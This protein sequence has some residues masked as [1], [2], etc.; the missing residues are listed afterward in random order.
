LKRLVTGQRCS[1]D[2]QYERIQVCVKPS[3]RGQPRTLLSGVT[4][5]LDRRSARKS[6]YCRYRELHRL[7]WSART[8]TGQGTASCFGKWE[9][10]RHVDARARWG[11]RSLEPGGR[12]AA[13][14]AINPLRRHIRRPAPANDAINNNR[15]GLLSQ[16]CV[17]L[18]RPCLPRSPGHVPVFPQHYRGL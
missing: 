5:V 14:A 16:S 1:L 3:R 8:A 17:R 9:Y 4:R 6:A 7:Y 12:A 10:M 15:V 13:N 18:S 2:E 11:V